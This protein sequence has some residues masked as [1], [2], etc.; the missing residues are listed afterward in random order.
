MRLALAV[1]LYLAAVVALVLYVG[2]G[3]VRQANAAHRWTWSDERAECR[4][5]R[6]RE[7]Q[8]ERE[9]AAAS[10]EGAA[11]KAREAEA[12]LRAAAR[13]VRRECPA[14]RAGE[15]AGRPH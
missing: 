11:K 15:Q 12:K 4:A 13:D 10:A 3:L 5:A 9:L 1:T 7:G 8:L 2:S 14:G 6:Q